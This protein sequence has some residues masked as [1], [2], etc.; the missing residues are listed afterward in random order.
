MVFI[1]GA[2]TTH[3]Y[4]NAV[5]SNAELACICPEICA[6]ATT[7]GTIG[8]IGCGRLA[9]AG[10]HVSFSANHSS[11]LGHRILIPYEARTPRVQS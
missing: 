2:A 9:C 6:V 3:Q 10:C 1:A 11:Q 8:A 4:G 7:S 5:G